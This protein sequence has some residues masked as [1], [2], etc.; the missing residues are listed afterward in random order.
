MKNDS[1]NKIRLGIFITVG[2]VVFILAIYFIG[3]KQQLF[4]ST[5]NISGVFK[6]VGGLQV[7]GNVRFAGINVG[8]VEGISIIT[9][10]SVQVDMIIDESVRK[11]I[12]KNAIANIGTEGL[13][14]NKILFISPG[15]G[16]AITIQD[17]DVIRTA[18]PINL[19]EIFASLKGTIDNTT[20]ITG[21][22]AKITTYIKDGKGIVG[23]LL[24]DDDL[25][26]NFD[27]A[28]ALLK[29][30]SSGFNTLIKSTLNNTET[31]SADLMTIVRNVKDGNGSVGRL[32]M[33]PSLAQ[34]LDSVMT[35]LKDGSVGLKE[36]SVNVNKNLGKNIDSVM[37][38]LKDGT[39][40]LKMLLEKAQS[41]WLLWGF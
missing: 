6:D 3:E 35:N 25:S 13:M 16:K 33:D 37:V 41:S 5:F 17:M 7:G 29:S 22:L 28:I 9:D 27:S 40:N 36:L 4:R 34:N 11:F 12:N 30:G 19:D 15:K 38:N 20:V 18:P 32:L 8:V 1:K 14:G 23:R 2:I 39:F 24:M 26:Q 21:D 31:M 10:T